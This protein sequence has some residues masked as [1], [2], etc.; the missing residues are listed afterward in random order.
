MRKYGIEKFLCETL[1]ETKFPEKREMEIIA[2]LGSY[3]NGYN[4]T[5]GG[6]G[7]KYINLNMMEVIKDYNKSI[8]VTLISI[9]KKY[10]V[11]TGTMSRLLKSHGVVVRTSGKTRSISIKKTDSEGKVLA[12]FASATEAANAHNMENGSHIIK[13]AKGKKKM[14][15]GFNWEYL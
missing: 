12:I 4:A 9:S 5:L 11:D 10:D 13:C 8:N 3:V 1:E 14:A 15:G 2:E 7:R 6:D